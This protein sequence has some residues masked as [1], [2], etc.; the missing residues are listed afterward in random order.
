MQTA[1]IK[2]IIA[3][4]VAYPLG[5][6][7]RTLPNKNLKHLFSFLGGFALLQFV[8]G[9]AWIHTLISSAVTYLLCLIAPPKY[10]HI[11][12]FVWVMGYMTFSH[13]F[14]MYV[15][16][17]S[18]IFD[19][20]G[21]QMVITMK[22]TSFAY[23]L[24]DGTYDHEIVFKE[25]SDKSLSRMYT[26]RKHFAITKLPNLLEYFGYV[27]C[28]TCLL[29]G[30]AF[31]YTDYVSAIDGSAYI[32]KFTDEKEKEKNTKMPPSFL[33][34]LRRFVTSLICMV[35]YLKV[36]PIWPISSLYDPVFISTHNHWQRL[37]QCFIAIGFEKT[38]Y[39]FA[40]K[41]AEASSIWAGF[42]FEGYDA[43]GKELG[44]R[45]VENVDIIGFEL[46]SNV[47]SKTRHWNKR[48][49]GWL[50]RYTY[51][52][53]NKSLVMTYFISA[54]WHGLYPGF[55]LFF[56]SIP[57]CTSI[58]RLCR[59]KLNPIFVPTYNGR[60]LETYPRTLVGYLYTAV[61][62]LGTAFAMHYIGQVREIMLN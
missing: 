37:L 15:S 12:V 33:P 54:F 40:W 1:V 14:R 17:F 39:Y 44:W 57:I 61:C 7:L 26:D 50:E 47:Q 20:T 62:W 42:G 55:F 38:K 48:T 28:F 53:T 9:P 19:F 21:T 51:N 23:N 32:N 36:A 35:L 8:Y 58:E 49:Q 56:L 41:L 22:L 24:Y 18:G 10:Q 27:F 46:A 6:V 16:Y 25:H 59:S 13:L 43:T 30:P 4:F 3:L 31:E 60:D 5:G 34:S 29:A 52:R 2:F 45:G 11:I